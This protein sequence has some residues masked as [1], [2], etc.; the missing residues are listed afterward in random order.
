MIYTIYETI[1]IYMNLKHRNRNFKAL[2]SSLRVFFMYNKNIAMLCDILCCAHK[3]IKFC[4]FN[5]FLLFKI[6]KII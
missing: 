5:L 4:S 6:I 2:K 1:Y 3:T